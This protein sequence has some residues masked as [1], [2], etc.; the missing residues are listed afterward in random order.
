MAGAATGDVER[1]ERDD[2]TTAIR[3]RLRPLIEGRHAPF[4]GDPRHWAYWRRELDAYASG[5]LPTG[6]ALRAPHCIGIVDDTL[7][8]ED[9][10]GPPPTTAEAAAALATW[11]VPYADDL[12]R[13]W[14]ATDQIGRRLR[15]TGE[16]DWS[17][18][19]ADPRAVE[20]WSRRYEHVAR[21]RT[22]PKVLSHGDFSIG[23][24]ARVD[25]GTVIAYDWA[26]FG[27][28][29]AGFDLAHLALSTGEVPSG[30]D[31]DTGFRCTVAIVGA[32]R[33]HWMLE[34]GE[35]P[36]SWYVDFLWEHRP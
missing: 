20:L 6:P 3:K 28:E 11:R 5:L 25:A 33:V 27:W 14:L 24:L 21:L 9:V 8:L 18:I 15:A 7:E 31:T 26:T 36:P 2:G 30:A 34:R 17:A 23:N 4:A 16:L 19:D 32:S 13:P 35:A 12:D 1:I 10:T 22:L 29:P